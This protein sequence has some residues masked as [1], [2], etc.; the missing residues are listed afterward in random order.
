MPVPDPDGDAELP[1]PPR[2]AADVLVPPLRPAELRRELQRLEDERDGALRQLGGQVVEMAEQ[3]ALSPARLADGAAAVRSRQAQI[4]ALSGALGG[5]T[6]SPRARTR[7]ATLLA[8]L[9]AVAILGAVAGAWIERRH[10]DTATATPPLVPSA[11]TETVTT[12][13]TIRVAPPATRVRNA[14]RSVRG[15][16]AVARRR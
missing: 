11:V 7:R 15:G 8:A 10:A 13:T 2:P 16:R 1:L 4:D 5:K 12:T 14:V 3:G 9:V 6:E